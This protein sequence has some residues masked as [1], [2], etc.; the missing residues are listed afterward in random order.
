ML[1]PNQIK[2]NIDEMHVLF[3]VNDSTVCQSCKYLT[4]GKNGYY[5][6]QWGEN[7]KWSKKFTACGLCK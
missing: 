4:H 2:R 1:I 5:C 3:G 6:S 7:T